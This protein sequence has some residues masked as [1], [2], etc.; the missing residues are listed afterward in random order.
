MKLFIDDLRN[1][2]DNSWTVVRSYADGVELISRMQGFPE[3]ISFDHDL[4][5]DETGYDFANWLVSQDLDER[6][7]IPPHF[8]FNV[9]SANPVGKRNINELLNNYLKF[10]YGAS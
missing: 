2:P 7:D 1:P 6:I 4:G 9:H 10:K 3:T 8:T 5:L